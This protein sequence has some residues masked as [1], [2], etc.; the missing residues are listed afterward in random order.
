MFGKYCKYVYS[1]PYWQTT[2][3]F[4]A[5][6]IYCVQLAKDE[7]DIKVQNKGASG[8]TEKD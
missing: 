3:I 4:N 7:A 8:P 2:E 5:Q 1:L 6:Y